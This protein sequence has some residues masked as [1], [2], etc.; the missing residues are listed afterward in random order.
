MIKRITAIALCLIFILSLCACSAKIDDKLVGT[1]KYDE[2]IQYEFSA[3]GEGCICQDDSHFVYTYKANGKKLQLFF[4]S[5][6]LVNSVYTYTIVENELTIVGGEG[7][8]GGTY[9]LTKIS[10]FS[11]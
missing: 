5:N 2:H 8:D 1:W 3:E 9:K 4:E 6:A 10:Q 7:T 11:K